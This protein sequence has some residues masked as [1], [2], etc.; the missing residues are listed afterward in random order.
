[1]PDR[2]PVPKKPQEAEIPSKK[3]LEK[4]NLTTQPREISAEPGEPVVE[5]T[6]D[7]FKE[8]FGDTYF[9]ETLAKAEGFN[10]N[11][12]E[13]AFRTEEYEFKKFIVTPDHPS[14]YFVKDLQLSQ[15]KDWE[16]AP[17]SN[18]LSFAEECR[19][20]GAFNTAEFFFKKVYFYI[21][22]KVS[23]DGFGRKELGTKRE[24]VTTKTETSEK[25][26]GGFSFLGKKR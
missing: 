21:L 18:I 19:K 1:M 3:E 4:E 9:K 16:I 20:I 22:L 15:L 13:S 12:G 8:I 2:I 7:T 26:S 25:Q 24:E 17:L 10:A 5:L 6:E 11:A 23:V 14:P